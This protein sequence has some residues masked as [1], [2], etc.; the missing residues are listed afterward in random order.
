MLFPL[1]SGGLNPQIS[2]LE[3]LCFKLEKE[4]NKVNAFISFAEVPLLIPCFRGKTLYHP[5][6]LCIKKDDQEY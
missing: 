1:L 5:H 4:E 6:K 2:H 3:I